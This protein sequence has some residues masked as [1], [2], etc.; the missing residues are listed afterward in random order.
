MYVGTIGNTSTIFSIFAFPLLY[1]IL[2]NIARNLPL[3][4]S[5]GQLPLAKLSA[6][7][8]SLGCEVLLQG[9]S[10]ESHCRILAPLNIC[11]AFG[12]G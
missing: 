7:I 3:I 8:V 2:K 10:G 1:Q 9:S 5:E 6:Y 11:Y 4:P 12:M